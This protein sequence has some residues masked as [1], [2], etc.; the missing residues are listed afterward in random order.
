MYMYFE[1]I[2]IEC[3]SIRVNLFLCVLYRDRKFLTREEEWQR[4]LLYS[5]VTVVD[6]VRL[7]TLSLISCLDVLRVLEGT[8]VKG[9]VLVLVPVFDRTTGRTSRSQWTIGT[10]S[11]GLEQD[12]GLENL[13]KESS[14]RKHPTVVPY[15][16]QRESIYESNVLSLP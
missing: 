12:G 10:V 3:Y 13:Q 1:I 9:L 8:Q 14:R 7:W 15:F 11:R 5:G 16:S 4:P 6:H 2:I